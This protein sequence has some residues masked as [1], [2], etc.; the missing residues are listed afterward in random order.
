VLLVVLVDLYATMLLPDGT[1]SWLLEEERP[2]E[3]LGALGLL[4][5][6][7]LCLLLCVTSGDS[8]APHGGVSSRYWASRSSSSWHSGKRSAGG[9]GS[10]ASARRIP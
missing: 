9:S 5:S 10:S 8:R 6:S 4:T 2:L 1:I 3:G 7:I